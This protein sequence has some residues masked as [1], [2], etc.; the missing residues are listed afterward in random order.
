MK[1]RYETADDFEEHM[2]FDYSSPLDEVTSHENSSFE[3]KYSERL[4]ETFQQE[5]SMNRLIKDGINGI[6]EKLNNPQNRKEFQ[7]SKSWV[8]KSDFEN[9][10]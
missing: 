5:N 2:I 1:Y 9:K 10:L 4:D 7:S 6:N 8:D 3:L